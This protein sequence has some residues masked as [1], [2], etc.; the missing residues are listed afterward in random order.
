MY[1]NGWIAVKETASATSSLSIRKVHGKGG[2]ILGFFPLFPVSSA[3]VRYLGTSGIHFSP[4]DRNLS[5]WILSQFSGF[6]YWWLGPTRFYHF[7]DWNYRGEQQSTIFKICANCARTVFSIHCALCRKK[8]YWIGWLPCWEWI[9]PQRKKLLCYLVA[10]I[11]DGVRS[12]FLPTC[13]KGAMQ[14]LTPLLARHNK[15]THQHQRVDASIIRIQ[16]AEITRSP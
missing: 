3:R 7:L 4:V 6:K 15:H 12:C 16:E 13:N 5:W 2:L 1:K 11:D 10:P 14:D 9:H 8:I